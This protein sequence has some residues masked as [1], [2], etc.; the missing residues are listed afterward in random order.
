MLGFT[1][2]NVIGQLDFYFFFKGKVSIYEL[3][4]SYC[5]M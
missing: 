4:I 2:V 1:I 5:D 3:V